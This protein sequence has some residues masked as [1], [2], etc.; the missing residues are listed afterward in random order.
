MAVKS[1]IVKGPEL[2]IKKKQHSNYYVYGDGE[3][4]PGANVIKLFTSVNTN[5]R[6]KLE[7]LSLACL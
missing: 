6:N 1:F 4:S 5:V 7:C 3:I 2:I